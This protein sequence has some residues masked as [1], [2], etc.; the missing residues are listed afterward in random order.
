MV[1]RGA[2]ALTM[3]QHIDHP[4]LRAVVSS[5][6]GRIELVAY[7]HPV[8]NVLVTSITSSESTLASISTWAL[9]SSA[10]PSRATAYESA[11][12]VTR[13]AV[14]TTGIVLHNSTRCGADLGIIGQNLTLQ[15]CEDNCTAS[16]V[17]GAFSYCDSA[18]GA[19]G[20]A[21][22]GATSRCFQFADMSVCTSSPQEVGWTSGMS[23]TKRPRPDKQ[24]VAAL[25]TASDSIAGWTAAARPAGF[26]DGKFVECR[27]EVSSP[28]ALEPGKAASMVTVFVDNSLAGASAA[29]VTKLAA[30]RAAAAVAPG[31][32][33]AAEV[34]EAVAQ[35]WDEYWTKS[36]ISLPS[37]PA[38]ERFWFGAQYIVGSMAST[39]PRVPASGL[40]GPWVTSDKPAWNGDYTLDYVR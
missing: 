1:A 37:R 18:V 9:N 8:D 22:T 19:T 32:N 15:Q 21:T 40:Y 25:A 26:A 3:E 29:A 33:T 38:I 24:I 27:T 39:N 11:G 30:T 23:G 17:C 34:N 4:R 13:H 31:R 14:A 12:A 5:E 20:C 2:V 6:L 16:A 7:L 10:S 36:A 28:L 35:W